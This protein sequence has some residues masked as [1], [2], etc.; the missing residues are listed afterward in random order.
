MKLP[1]LRPLSVA[2]IDFQAIRSRW[3]TFCG[4]QSPSLM[5][6]LFLGIQIICGKAQ[7]PASLYG[8]VGFQNKAVHKCAR[9]HINQN[10][11]CW[12]DSLPLLH[13][14]MDP[15]FGFNV[16]AVCLFDDWFCLIEKID[17]RPGPWQRF[18]N[19]P[20]LCF[21]EPDA[22]PMSTMSQCFNIASPC[23]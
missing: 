14:L 5:D 11:R 9:N 20:R 17:Q 1:P 13:R 6:R 12:A 18:L 7:A 22:C 16:Q 19:L 21:A 15:W 4:A 8:G 2:H 3:V 23:S 10:L